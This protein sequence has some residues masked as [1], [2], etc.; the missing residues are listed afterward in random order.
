M[1]PFTKKSWIHTAA[2]MALT[3]TSHVYA[4]FPTLP[5]TDPSHVMGVGNSFLGNLGNACTHLERLLNDNGDPEAIQATCDIMFGH[6]LNSMLDDAVIS[7]AESGN[8]N[9]GMFIS[10][11]MQDMEAFTQLYSD[12]CMAPVVLMTWEEQNPARG[13]EEYRAH[14]STIAHRMR[15][16]ESRTSA[17]II[18]YGLVLY[19]LTLNPP[20]PLAHLPVHY[21]YLSN[22]NIHDNDLSFW[23]KA[24]TIY[25]TLLQRSPEGIALDPNFFGSLAISEVWNSGL[26]SEEVIREMQRR[27]WDLV[28][29]WQSG[30]SVESLMELHDEPEA[31]Y[32]LIINNGNGDGSYPAGAVVNIQADPAQP[33]WNFVGWQGA[34]EHLL[35]N[36]QSTTL[37]MPAQAIS[38]TAVYEPV[39]DNGNSFHYLR[40]EFTNI[41][42]NG[43]L[44][45]LD[46]TWLTA[47][48]SPLVDSILA[49][50]QGDIRLTTNYPAAAHIYRAFDA[51]T[52]SWFYMNGA[53][54]GLPVHIT[55]HSEIPLTPHGIRLANPSWNNNLQ[56]FRVLGS[57]DGSTWELIYETDN[58]TAQFQSSGSIS[59]A[60][61]NF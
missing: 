56:G 18:P 30:E 10:G 33:G 55:L 5:L 21:L 57:Q 58:A 15:D 14:I 43:A 28:Q 50:Q 31:R 54:H 51:D 3:L 53:I 27:I 32:S 13:V 29:R 9:V 60:Q 8:Y 22:T 36:S 38:L 7:N 19:H 46:A 24:N 20:E 12:N 44:H 17:R 48:N 47:D 40:L 6:R 49:N 37:V 39:S 23:L 4:C 42:N 59:T 2:V 25:A 34:V 26:L 52:G 11:E 1:R 61:F 45:L 41:I 16:L 35:N